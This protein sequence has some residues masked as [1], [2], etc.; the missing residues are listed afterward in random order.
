MLYSWPAC[1]S[2]SLHNSRHLHPRMLEFHTVRPLTRG[3][4]Q[5]CLPSLTQL[6]EAASE[7]QSW[8]SCGLSPNCVMKF[9]HES[10]L[11]HAQELNCS[12]KE[13]E[14]VAI[15]VQ[16]GGREFPGFTSSRKWSCSPRVNIRWLVY[17]CIGTVGSSSITFMC[18]KACLGIWHRRYGSSQTQRTTLVR[19]P[20]H[21][22]DPKG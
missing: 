20:F 10:S 13:E 15:V 18:T 1:W 19:R 14:E 16:G 7:A 8:K 9:S 4:A 5:L 12:R 6:L 21:P 11:L 17:R 22:Y 2:C 3:E